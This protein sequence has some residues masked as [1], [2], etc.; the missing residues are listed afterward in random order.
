MQCAS[1]LDLEDL[2]CNGALY[3]PINGGWQWLDGSDGCDL[4][5]LFCVMN[6]W[7]VWFLWELVRFHIHGRPASRNPAC[8]KSC[9]GRKSFSWMLQKSSLNS[10]VN[11]G[12]PFLQTISWNVFP[13]MEE[14]AHGRPRIS[15]SAMCH[16]FH[17][18]N[19][20]NRFIPVGAYATVAGHLSA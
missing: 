2:H 20:P 13:R 14:V 4:C 11:A 8:C 16:F 5:D 7:F 12:P 9:L 18:L 19:A 15:R 10:S 6:L 17:S 1:Y 3:H